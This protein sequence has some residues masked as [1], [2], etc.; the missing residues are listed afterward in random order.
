MSQKIRV[1]I[2]DDDK[3]TRK[4]Y[5][6]LLKGFPEF[7]VREAKN[8]KEALNL[9]G[10]STPDIVVSD[11]MMPEMDGLELCATSRAIRAHQP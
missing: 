1:L 9:I 10:E 7:Q 3:V 2:V 8:G 6:G 4:L 11:L 5:R